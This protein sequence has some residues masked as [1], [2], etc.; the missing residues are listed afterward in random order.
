MI[1]AI[2]SGRKTGGITTLKKLAGALDVDLEN[3]A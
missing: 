1:A 2:E 3:L